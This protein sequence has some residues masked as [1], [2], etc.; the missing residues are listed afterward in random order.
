MWLVG[1]ADKDGQ[2][3]NM[4]W[5]WTEAHDFER[6]P[7]RARYQVIRIESARDLETAKTYPGSRGRLALELA[8]AE[9]GLMR[10]MDFV[11]E[12]GATAKELGVPVILSG[13]TLGHAY[14]ALRRQDCA[15]ITLGEK[16]FSRSR[17]SVT[18][19]K[20]VRDKIPARIAK[21][22]ELG[23]T[24]RVPDQLKK[25]FL[26]SK[27]LEEA[28]EVRNAVGDEEK[29]V[30]MADLLEVVR[31]LGDVQ[32]VS[33]AQMLAAADKKRNLAGGFDEGLIL[34]QTAITGKGRVSRVDGD[35]ILTQMLAR[36][37]SDSVYELPFTFFGFMEMDQ[38]RSLQYDD[39]NVTLIIT[40][41]SDRIELQ[42]SRGTE[43]LELPL[44]DFVE[45]LEK[46]E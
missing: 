4:P 37:L 30:E 11:G 33:F 42:I 39:P 25:G 18:F 14:F 2:S 46:S 20:L 43:Q 36:K 24:R 45:Q 26:T 31:S 13:S 7:D 9:L 35:V 19:G 32:G 40:L 17:R 15:V 16:E 38:P 5:Y 22:E 10:D 3:F 8:P 28:L 29:T 12:V 6:N 21:R 1:C 27:L 34:L 23:V 44:E 41:R